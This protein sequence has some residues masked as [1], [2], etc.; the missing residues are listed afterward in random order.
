MPDQIVVENNDKK[1]VSDVEQKE[2][3]GNSAVIKERIEKLKR[4]FKPTWLLDQLNGPDN[5]STKKN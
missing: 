5:I 2:S 3:K 4:A 1:P